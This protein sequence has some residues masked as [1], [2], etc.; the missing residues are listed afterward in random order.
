VWKK[1]ESSIAHAI[2]PLA[3]LAVSSSPPNTM[4]CM[5]DVEK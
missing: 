3:E 5:M 2:T 1:N 4:F